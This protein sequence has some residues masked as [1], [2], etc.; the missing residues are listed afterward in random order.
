MSYGTRPRGIRFRDFAIAAPILLSA[1][2]RGGDGTTNHGI[3]GRY[4]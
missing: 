3:A 2:G 4:R 1:A